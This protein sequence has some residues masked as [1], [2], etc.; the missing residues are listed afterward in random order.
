MRVSGSGW[1]VLW[2]SAAATLLLLAGCGSARQPP[3]ATSAS[4]PEARFAPV[5]THE[6]RLVEQGAPLVVADGCSACHLPGRTTSDAPSFLDFAGHRVILRS[7]RRAV[8]NERFLRAALL[9]PARDPIRGYDPA[10][11]IGVAQ[12]LDLA[13]HPQQL[14][15]LI[16]FIEQV[17]PETE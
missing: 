17:G 3:D 8:V 16:A 15:A 7:G 12:R 11:M 1:A 4:R 13:H 10:A 9:H 6:Q 5:Y 14:A 2:L